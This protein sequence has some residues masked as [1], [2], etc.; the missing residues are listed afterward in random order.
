M[1]TRKPG[2]KVSQTVEKAIASWQVNSSRKDLLGSCRK[3][4]SI[5]NQGPSFVGRARCR[6]KRSHSSERPSSRESRVAWFRGERNR[7]CVIFLSTA[8]SLTLQAMG[9]SS[10]ESCLN[11][12]DVRDVCLALMTCDIAVSTNNAV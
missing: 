5:D 11:F 2:V 1:Y 3:H 10:R 12:G 8:R 4:V 9:W 6:D 7:S